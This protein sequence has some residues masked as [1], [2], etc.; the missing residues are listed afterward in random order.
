M[1]FTTLQELVGKFLERVSHVNVS[2]EAGDK[3]LEGSDQ[4]HV[5]RVIAIHQL[6]IKTGLKKFGDCVEMAVKKEL[7]QLHDMNTYESTDTYQMTTK[8]Q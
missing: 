8:P 2:P 3:I 5:L 4:A 7:I 1:L 6:S